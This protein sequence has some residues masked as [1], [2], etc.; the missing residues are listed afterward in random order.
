MLSISAKGDCGLVYIIYGVVGAL[1]GIAVC[2]GCFGRGWRTQAKVSERFRTTEAKALGEQGRAMLIEQQQAF[3]SMMN[4]SPEI[5][6]G[7][8]PAEPE[9][10]PNAGRG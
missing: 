9:P 7:L 10:E 1:L 8:E 6:Y 2:A 3:R 5:A 4:Y